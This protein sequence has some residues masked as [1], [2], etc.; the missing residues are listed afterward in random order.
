MIEVVKPFLFVM[1]VEKVTVKPVWF[2]EDEGA[3]AGVE[4]A[5]LKVTV[6]EDDPVAF[7]AVTVKTVEANDT[8]GVPEKIPVEV[9]KFRPPE[10]LGETE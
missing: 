1:T 10:T 3:G 2:P 8:E 4:L 7:V 9:E 6:A 5:V